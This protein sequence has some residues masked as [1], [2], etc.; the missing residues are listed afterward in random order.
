VLSFLTASGPLKKLKKEHFVQSRIGPAVGH[1]QNVGS[2]M[3]SCKGLIRK[4]GAVDGT[5]SCQL[6]LEK[7]HGFL[8]SRGLQNPMET[9]LIRL[10]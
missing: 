5:S 4:A 9:N 8:Q 6:V 7:Y 1:G 10:W 3:E 2:R